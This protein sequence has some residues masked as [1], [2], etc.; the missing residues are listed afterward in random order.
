[1]RLDAR[2]DKKRVDC[3]AIVQPPRIADPLKKSRYAREIVAQVD[4]ITLPL[5]HKHTHTH[6]GRQT[7]IQRRRMN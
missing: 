7:R 1:M 6:T 4:A 3:L 5:P 2:A